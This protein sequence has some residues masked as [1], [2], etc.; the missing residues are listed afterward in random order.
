MSSQHA[1][2]GSILMPI[3]LVLKTELSADAHVSALTQHNDRIRLLEGLSAR[4]LMRSTRF[5]DCYPATS[6]TCKPVQKRKPCKAVVV[7]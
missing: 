1:R 2:A 5:A 7:R 6:H 4:S 3:D